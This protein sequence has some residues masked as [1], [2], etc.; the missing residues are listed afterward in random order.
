MTPAIRR[1]LDGFVAI[2]P[3]CAIIGAA[4]MQCWRRVCRRLFDTRPIEWDYIHP[5]LVIAGHREGL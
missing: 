5:A 1:C 3:I 2:L 4:V